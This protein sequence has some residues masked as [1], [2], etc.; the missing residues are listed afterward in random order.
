MRSTSVVEYQCRRN[1][2]VEC[3]LVVLE[4]LGVR[5]DPAALLLMCAGLP[6]IG[7]SCT[8]ND[9]YQVLNS[10][11]NLWQSFGSNC[12]RHCASN[13]TLFWSLLCRQ[14]D[15]AIA[16]WK[17]VPITAGL[18]VT[19]NGIRM[20]RIVTFT[21]IDET[22]AFLISRGR[23]RR[24][25]KKELDAPGFSSS[26]YQV[27]APVVTVQMI[28]SPERVDAAAR[29]RSVVETS[30]EYLRSSPVALPALE[31]FLT[32]KPSSKQLDDYR[33][34]MQCASDSSPTFF[35]EEFSLAVRRYKGS[36]D[37]EQ[38]AEGF[39][40]SGALHE[41]F[42]AGSNDALFEAAHVERLCLDGVSQQKRWIR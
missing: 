5:A 27:A 20:T 35:R 37:A 2:I 15:V 26:W 25:D 24:F 1:P 29:A 13:P 10:A 31:H 18:G 8:V 34:R 17:A 14:N 36:S 28:T 22:G 11:F 33:F 23:R 42:L 32:T 19:I 41:E 12:E 38:I 3:G 6:Y 9:P 40:R 7:T 30:I 39:D 16:R 21:D 4:S